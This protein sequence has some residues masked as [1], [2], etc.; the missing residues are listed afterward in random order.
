M[1]WPYRATDAEQMMA[2]GNV[3]RRRPFPHDL[4][5]THVAVQYR[6]HHRNP[7][8]MA[9]TLVAPSRAVVA[10]DQTGPA[11]AFWTSRRAGSA[12]SR[13]LQATIT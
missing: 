8:V 1:K 12:G 13:H 10:C 4:V 2:D 6:R 7:S 9:P 3:N 11:F 5:H